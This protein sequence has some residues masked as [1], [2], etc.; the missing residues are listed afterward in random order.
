MWHRIRVRLSALFRKREVEQDLDEELR[1]HLEKETERN[2][3]GGM[4]REQARRAA[5]RGFG[6]VEQIKEE[7]REARGTRFIEELGQDVRYG[8][9]TSLRQP[10]FTL[11]AVV[12]L[13]LGIGANTTIFSVIN[14]LL[15]KPIP[16][17]DADRLV[18]VW[19]TQVNDPQS[20][21]IVSAPNFLDWQ[22]QNDI[23]TS[24]AV[25][26]SAGKGYNLSGDGEPQRVS[27]VRVSAS[28][29]D[30]LGVEPRLGRSFLPEEET[31]GK[32]R[33]VVLGDGL[34]RS[35]YNADPALVGKTIKV[36]GEDFTVIGVTPPEFE[37]QF[38]SGPR[39]LW[40]PIFYTKGD[41]DRGS[42][43][44][45]AV[46]RLKPNV[47]TE[48]ARARMNTIGLGLAQ[49]Y[50]KDN[51]GRSATVELIGEFGLETQRST[52]FTLLSVAGFVLLIACVNVANLLTASGA[53]RQREFAIRSAL[54]ASR[55]R[56]IRQLLTES[57]L[58]AVAGG[59]GGILVA[60]WTSSLL[61]KVLPDNLR[62]VPFRSLN[63]ITIDFKVLAFTWVITCLTGVLFGL[64]PALLFSRRNANES[65]QEGS[66]GTT[67]GGAKLRQALVVIEVAL[68]L[69][70]LTGAGLMVQ[71]MMRLL[72]VAPGLDPKNVLTMNI[73]LPQENL[74]YG[75]PAH[76]QFARNLQEQVGSIPGV[77]SASA[78]SHLPIG[79]GQAGRGF[80][81]EGRPDPGSD[82][83]PGGGYSVVCPN[84]FRTMG[85][86]LVS[87][88]EFT[89]QDTANAPGVI[90]INEAMSRQY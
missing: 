82:N 3:A 47:T 85:I 5:L 39:Q 58:L 8:L 89:E 56:A 19:E 74:Y 14:S 30:V 16:F 45:I 32:H 49:E 20:R 55:A 53:M 23:F 11:I 7:C 50:P 52:L 42:H 73:S 4:S 48:Q 18:L 67:G 51:V 44:F 22:R 17:P 68:A 88:R 63:E 69:I 62:A 21:N 28:F 1:Y 6:G 65:L 84:Y 10:G 38:W 29:F 66:R 83:Q 90:I 43:S 36:D 37:F 78:V 72:N 80:V 40:V 33:V 2:V 77:V 81:I 31:F 9:R 64:A 34:W 76:P 54:G 26:D 12:T 35:R 79:G 25:F 59:L 57:S 75:P 15:L 24:M 13:S 70:V 87:G 86:K 41:Q 61:L 71:S 60:I 46:A 27:G